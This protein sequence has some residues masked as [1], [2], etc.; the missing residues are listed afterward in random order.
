MISHYVKKVA[1]E[2]FDGLA[3]PVSAR[4]RA[5]LEAGEWDQ[6][7]DL[8]VDPGNYT[9][10]EAYWRDASAA[11]FL[12]KYEPLPT[13]FNKPKVAEENF[14]ICERACF[15]TNRRLYPY[16]E[17]FS[18]P[19][20]DTGVHSFFRR[21]RKNIADLLGPCPDLVT[22]RFGPG[23]TYGDRGNLTTIPDKMSSEPTFTADAWPFLFPWSGTL[24]AKACCDIGK[25]PKSVPGNRF[26]TV[27]KDATKHRGIAIE[28]S[29]NVF[30]QLAYGKVIRTRLRRWGID[31]ND[32][33]DIHRRLACEASRR[34]HLAT[35]DLKNASDTISRNLVKLLLP[36]NWYN[37]L[38]ELRSKKTYFRDGFHL[39]EKFS[40]MGN[41]F[42]F[43]L[44]TLIFLGLISALKGVASIGDSVFAFGDDLILPVEDTKDVISM[45]SFCGLETNS[46]KSFSSGSFR[47]SCGGDFFNGVAVRPYF[48]KDDP[49]QPASRISL[50]NGLRRSCN[51]DIGRW[52]SVRDSWR[53][54]L[55][56]IPTEI[57]RLR[58]PSGLGDVVIHDDKDRWVYRWKHGIRYLMCYLPSPDL[59]VRWSRFAPSVTLA[60]AVYGSSWMNGYVLPRNPSLDY[61]IGEVPFS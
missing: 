50:A 1:I 56:G 21:A 25:V 32:G 59:T 53:E 3:T 41:G 5:L 6:L 38:D 51:D 58:G 17:D 14:I 34:G 8:Q 33:Q 44:E 4:A 57:R 28:P 52:L 18:N 29:I 60:S 20:C 48:L 43:E 46:K 16:I 13:S 15:R 31:L 40:S 27:P 10:A 49:D 42:T 24:W 47:E 45:L 61:H 55:W 37:V 30:Y 11:S 12:R 22:G 54:S 19:L 26:T 35:L 7:A 39:L 23:A 2:L 36:S 9:N